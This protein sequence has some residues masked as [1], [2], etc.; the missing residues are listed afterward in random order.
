VP[1]EALYVG[2]DPVALDLVGWAVVEAHRK[3]NGLPSLAEVG[4]E[5]AYLRRAGELG[6]G[7]ADANLIRLRDVKI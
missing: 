3:N 2:T 7:I 1:H 6:L 5:P 4:R